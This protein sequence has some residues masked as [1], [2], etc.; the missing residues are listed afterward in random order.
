M[1]DK[2]ASTAG[3]NND[4]EPGGREGATADAN[5]G[6]K[7]KGSGQGA[8]PFRGLKDRAKI[9]D[10]Y[11]KTD[12]AASRAQEVTKI[13]NDALAKNTNAQN[14]SIALTFVEN[15]GNWVDKANADVTFDQRRSSGGGEHG[16]ATA[17][18]ID[19]VDWPVNIVAASTSVGEIALKIAIITLVGSPLDVIDAAAD[20]LAKKFSSLIPDANVSSFLAEK[21]KSTIF[22]ELSCEIYTLEGE[23]IQGTVRRLR[24]SEKGMDAKA[25]WTVWDNLRLNQPWKPSYIAW[26][27]ELGQSSD[28]ELASASGRAG[29]ALAYR[30]L[31]FFNTEIFDAWV[32]PDR[33][34]AMSVALTTIISQGEPVTREWVEK[35]V[36]SCASNTDFERQWLAAELAL[37]ALGHVQPPLARRI[38]RALLQSDTFDGFYLALGMCRFWL[39]ERK[40]KSPVAE[41]DV[42]QGLLDLPTARSGGSTPSTE[43]QEALEDDRDWL[44][45]WLLYERSK[46]DENEPTHRAFL[47]LMNRAPSAAEPVAKLMAHII[48]VS[49][50]SDFVLDALGEMV[51]LEQRHGGAPG[52]S[53]LENHLLKALDDR[54]SNYVEGKFDRWRIAYS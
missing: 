32:L 35:S 14:I 25:L 16:E 47:E 2:D 8:E 18:D 53:R 6:A 48:P 7:E 43:K 20:K 17:S 12:P 33:P 27:R 4:C 49:K 46:G 5:A 54:Y 26:L 51:R 30:D 52:L 29:G 37:G 13:V 31:N 42:F 40:S 44:F 21:P 41:V 38:L 19:Q 39:F 11:A 34:Q 1:D 10:N 24:F 28:I 36:L 9:S 23:N 3:T 45:L 22:R 50:K 15:S